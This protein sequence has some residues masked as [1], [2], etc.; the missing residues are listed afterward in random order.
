MIPKPKGRKKKFK[1]ASK[2]LTVR[3]PAKHYYHIKHLITELLKQY[4]K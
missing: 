4:E 3:V 1:G 2:P